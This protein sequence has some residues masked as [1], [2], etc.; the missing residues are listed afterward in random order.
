MW[1]KGEIL[2]PR[3]DP[4]QNDGVCALRPLIGALWTCLV[5]AVTSIPGP[6]PVGADGEAGGD[7]AEDVGEDDFDVLPLKQLHRGGIVGQA[8]IVDCVT[9]YDF[10]FFVVTDPFVSPFT[11]DN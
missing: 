9:D 6:V 1:G 10:D 5:H 4:A 8:N 3:C 2:R 11:R 7:A